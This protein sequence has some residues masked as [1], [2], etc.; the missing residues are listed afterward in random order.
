MVF[1]LISPSE[2]SK[3]KYIC[4][5]G[6]LVRKDMDVNQHERLFHITL[7]HKLK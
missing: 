1:H 3:T 4:G 5:T 7:G 2:I 6:K